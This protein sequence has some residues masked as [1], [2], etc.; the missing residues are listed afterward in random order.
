MKSRLHNARPS[1]E[2][3]IWDAILQSGWGK[4]MS[5]GGE[6]CEWPGDDKRGA[7][8]Y[9]VLRRKGKKLVDNP[10]IE[11]DE[12]RLAPTQTQCVMR[13][14]CLRDG[15]SLDKLEHMY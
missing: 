11:I 10:C 1:P 6:G 4:R 7:S 8:R 12:G 15:Y 13:G 14:I 3:I 5:G 2:E 9:L